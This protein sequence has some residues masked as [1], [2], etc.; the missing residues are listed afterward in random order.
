MLLGA[1]PFLQ[2]LLILFLS[3]N[4]VK[5]CWMTSAFKS[6]LQSP[7][8]LRLQVRATTFRYSLG[9]KGACLGPGSKKWHCLGEGDMKPLRAGPSRRKSVTGTVPAKGKWDL[10]LRSSC[11]SFWLHEVSNL[12]PCV[13]A[14]LCCVTTDPAESPKTVKKVLSS[15]NADWRAGCSGGRLNLSTG[16]SSNE[17]LSSDPE[18]RYKTLFQGNQPTSQPTNLKMSSSPG[19]SVPC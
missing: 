11:F 14:I 2:S 1:K 18:P 10:S 12:R 9:L 13:P 5:L 15:L 6:S 19:S 3:R 7:E 8:E 4:F 16:G 17:V